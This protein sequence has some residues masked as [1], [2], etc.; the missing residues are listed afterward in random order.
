MPSRLIVYFQAEDGIR[1]IGVTGVQTCAL[2]ICRTMAQSSPIPNTT[3]AVRGKLTRSRNFSISSGS[4]TVPTALPKGGAEASFVGQ[5]GKLRATRRVP[6]LPAQPT[7]R[8]HFTLGPPIQL[9]TPERCLTILTPSERIPYPVGPR[10]TSTVVCPR[11][12]RPLDEP[13]AATTLSPPSPRLL[14]DSGNL[15]A[16]DYVYILLACSL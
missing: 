8:T 11:A 1:D 16:T 2:P 15:I 13:I 10:P 12:A 4:F 14:P 3:P 5:P 6:R 7:P 9:S